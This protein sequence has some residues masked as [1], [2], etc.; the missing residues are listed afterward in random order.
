MELTNNGADEHKRRSAN[1]TKEGD[2]GKLGSARTAVN[3]TA[4]QVSI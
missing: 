3:V 2:C 4:S 1:S